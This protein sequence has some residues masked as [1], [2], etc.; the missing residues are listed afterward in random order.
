MKYSIFYRDTQKK[1]LT[2]QRFPFNILMIA[3]SKQNP[4]ILFISLNLIDHFKIIKRKSVIK[5]AKLS[6]L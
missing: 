3:Q 1:L 4:Q 5:L 2:R 6:Y